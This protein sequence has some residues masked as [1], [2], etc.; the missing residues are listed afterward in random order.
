VVDLSQAMLET[1]CL[2]A[3]SV[4]EAW[5]QE[6]LT[7]AGEQAT[8]ESSYLELGEV[9]CVLVLAAPCLVVGLSPAEATE[10]IRQQSAGKADWYLTASAAGPGPNW[11]TK[12]ATK[13]PA[14]LAESANFLDL[15]QNCQNTRNHHLRRF[16]VTTL[17]PAATWRL[18]LT[19]AS[20]SSVMCH[21]R[22]I[23]FGMPQCWIGFVSR[24]CVSVSWRWENFGYL[25]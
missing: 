14:S 9:V 12:G 24:L 17:C 25:V 22:A 10:S 18:M 16:L 1:E 2:R 19:L 7:L 13:T 21:V 20:A 8:P 23:E 5:N 11:T 4:E 3:F 6:W 15:A